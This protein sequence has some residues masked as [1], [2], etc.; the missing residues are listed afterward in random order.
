MDVQPELERAIMSKVPLAKEFMT[1]RIVTLHPDMD[2][3]DAIRGL[4]KHHIS[5]A[6]VVED[7]MLVGI[8]SEKDCLNMFT[9]SVYDTIPG[10]VVRDYMSKKIVSCNQDDDLFAVAGIFFKNSFRR[11][12]V[13]ENG[14]LIGL[15]SRPDVL[16][17]S[18]ELWA[19]PDHKKKWS[20]SVYLTEEIKAAL[21]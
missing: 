5:G 14:K 2:I 18:M 1:R 7:G 13:L 11:L 9:K 20:D 19:E 4:L 6:P 10:G 21:Y 8:L 12:P 17:G 3:Y 16:K 15:V